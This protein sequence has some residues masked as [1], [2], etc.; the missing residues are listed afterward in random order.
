[1]MNNQDN[2]LTPEL[3]LEHAVWLR[4]LARELVRDPGA[5]DDLVQDTWLAALR[6]RPDLGRPLRPWLAR[7][8]RNGATQRL[9]AVAGRSARESR[10]ARPEAVPSA[11]ELVERAELQQVLVGAVL[12]LSEPYRKTLLLRFYEGLGPMQIAATLGLPT[13]TVRTHLHRGLQRLR[14]KLDRENGGNRKAW[15]LMLQPLVLETTL[16]FL[17]VVLGALVLVVA[18]TWGWSRWNSQDGEGAESLG[19]TTNVASG[20]RADGLESVD[21]QSLRAPAGTDIGL[22]ASERR[23]QL[24]NHRSRI[25]LPEFLVRVAGEECRTDGQGW[26]SVPLTASHLVPVDDDRLGT[27]SAS[28][29]R[30]TVERNLHP[31]AIAI[32]AGAGEVA[33]P[34]KVGPTY[35]LRLETS[36][37]VDAAQLEAI[38][39]LSE[40]QGRTPE[41]WVAPVRV[42]AELP[43]VRFANVPGGT[44]LPRTL[45]VRHPSGLWRGEAALNNV[46][47]AET[48]N[49]PLQAM[50][51]LQGRIDGVPPGAD[52]QVIMESIDD[53][54]NPINKG[55]RWTRPDGEGRYSLKYLAPGHYLM[56]VASPLHDVWSTRIQLHPA[57]VQVQ[58]VPLDPVATA[59]ALSG[60]IRSQ[61]G[62]YAGQLLVFLRDQN[63][64]LRD[65]YPT[66]WK[67]SPEHGSSAAFK[68]DTVPVGPLTLDVVSLAD[69]VTFEVQTVPLEGPNDGVDVLLLDGLQACD[70]GF[71]VVREDTGKAL[72]RFAVVVR[73]QGG[74]ERRFRARLDSDLEAGSEPIWKWTRIVGNLRW[75]DFEGPAALVGL[76]QA[77]R[78]TWRVQ[79][80]GFAEVSGD[81]AD[82]EP[83]GDGNRSVGV[84]MT[85][86]VPK[87]E[88]FK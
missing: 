26:V 1:M 5:A 36:T 8:M 52:T 32:P 21:L 10:V 70:W 23:L 77:A 57:V 82:F 22:V 83:L 2:V 29:H 51:V 24:V 66:T 65:V 49:M 17:V 79:A 74:F 33:L 9:R 81:Q 61:S 88:T 14:E 3:L 68:F 54:G 13:A 6:A 34:V 62:T 28:N 78:F 25:P 59:G 18:G 15:V 64:S 45:V 12:S 39:R 27:R 31:D 7:V 46:L 85:P 30:P 20:V 84:R 38:L 76:P 71:R 53:Q 44:A 60:I 58:D 86:L 47:D 48:L 67:P 37:V 75:N 72:E 63:Q 41:E 80:E 43:W 4:R 56:Q 35:H 16:P 73:V 55:V 87:S 11:R 19:T 40:T 42:G 50:S 69:E